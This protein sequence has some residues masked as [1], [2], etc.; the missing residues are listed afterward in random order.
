MSPVLPH[1]APFFTTRRRPVRRPVVSFLFALLS[2]TQ[3]QR[4]APLPR[5]HPAGAREIWIARRRIAPRLNSRFPV[6]HWWALLASL[7]NPRRP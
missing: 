2:Q 7:R 3:D 1:S 4:P 5:V 6:R